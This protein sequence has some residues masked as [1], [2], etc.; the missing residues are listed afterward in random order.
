MSALDGKALLDH[1]E[2]IARRYASRIGAEVAEELRGE[3]VLR[4]LR[5]PAPDGRMEPWLERIYKNLLID[6]W[7]RHWRRP[8]QI[9]VDIAEVDAIGAST[10]EDAALMAERRRLVR[11]CLRCLPREMRRVLLSRY[12]GELDEPTTASRLGIA[13]TT[14][15]TRVHR[16][17]ARLRTRLADL[18]AFLMPIFSRLAGQLVAVGAAPILVVTLIATGAPSPEPR[19]PVAVTAPAMATST[20]AP[21]VQP[22]A[23]P[24]PTPA[25]LRLRVHAQ[26]KA[27]VALPPA[28]LVMEPAAAIVTEILWP[29]RMDIFA[30]PPEPTPPSLVEV[31][32][33][34]ASRIVAMVEDEL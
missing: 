12:Y 16:A 2:A 22:Q 24:I 18:R 33:T 13:G 10:P 7:R 11:A 3:A 5:S 28:V 14:V 6:H 15:R 20:S 17:L 30:E 9:T 1:G 34:F 8:Q 4:A 31:P 26:T 27:P 19:L 25:T 29:D 32:T 23:Q 21:A